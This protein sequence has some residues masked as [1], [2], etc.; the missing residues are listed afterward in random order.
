MKGFIYLKKLSDGGPIVAFKSRNTGVVVGDET[1]QYPLGFFSRNWISSRDVYMWQ[2][3][4]EKSAKKILSKFRKL[5]L[6]KNL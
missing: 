1:D 2:S 3:I 5:K 6:I 4:S